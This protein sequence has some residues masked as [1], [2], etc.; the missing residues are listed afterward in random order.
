MIIL[1]FLLV[2]KVPYLMTRLPPPPRYDPG[3]GRVAHDSHQ[4]SG[5]YKRFPLFRTG[6]DPIL[7]KLAAFS[8][9]RGVFVLQLRRCM[10]SFSADDCI[11]ELESSKIACSEQS[12][13][14][15]FSLI[16]ISFVIHQGLPV[17]YSPRARARSL[18]GGKLSLTSPCRT[19]Y[20]MI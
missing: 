14:N 2:P 7:I 5:F 16:S 3:S 12:S 9:N 11:D 20:L 19:P 4:S 10:H 13:I 6:C 17:G 1:Y 8:I 18:T 15:E